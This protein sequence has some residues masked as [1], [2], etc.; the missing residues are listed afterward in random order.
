M[1][2][3]AAL[4]M[5]VYSPVVAALRSGQ[6]CARK[7]ETHPRHHTCDRFPVQNLHRSVFPAGDR[8]FTEQVA[9]C[10]HVDPFGRSQA[11]RDGTRVAQRSPSSR[12]AARRARGPAGHGAARGHR[13]RPPRGA[14]RPRSRT[15]T[16]A[17]SQSAYAAP[18]LRKEAKKPATRLPRTVP[19]ACGLGCDRRARRGT[20]NDS[21]PA[22]RRSIHVCVGSRKLWFSA[23]FTIGTS[24]PQLLTGM[25]A[26]RSS[27]TCDRLR[28]A[29]IC[30]PPLTR[31]VAAG[32]R[33][34][35][36]AAEQAHTKSG[37]SSPGGPQ[38]PDPLHQAHRCGISEHSSCSRRPSQ[39][40]PPRG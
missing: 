8:G 11:T 10:A 37:R 13:P 34:V 29:P 26:T 5:P 23:V 9:S 28:W 40:R 12:V 33:R 24:R 22:V 30:E 15:L 25:Y 32:H 1:G 6:R 39:P 16:H 38:P 31:T 17:R 21:R 35:A 20:A 27:S 14:R 19:A 3:K 7:I 2:L 18:G 36:K 4:C